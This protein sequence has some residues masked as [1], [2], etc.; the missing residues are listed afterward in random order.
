MEQTKNGKDYVVCELDNGHSFNVFSWHSRYGEFASD[1]DSDKQIDID[2]DELHMKGQYINLNEPGKGI[3]KG[4][5]HVDFGKMEEK[6]EAQTSRKEYSIKLASTARIATDLL[7]AQIQA[8]IL[9]GKG[10]ASLKRQWVEWRSW[11]SDQWE[12]MP[13]ESLD[14]DDIINS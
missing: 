7:T 9:D 12:E 6:Q 14:P 10:K 11:V 3:P 13:E 5:E 4:G 8:G 1:V 2:K